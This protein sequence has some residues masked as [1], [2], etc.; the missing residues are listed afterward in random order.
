M[1]CPSWSLK[2]GASSEV[3]GELQ[4]K[5]LVLLSIAAEAIS[6][7][8]QGRNGECSG[9]PKAQTHS[10]LRCVHQFSTA[11]NLDCPQPHNNF[12]W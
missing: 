11:I 1:H 10:D 7:Q 4:K 6:K 5:E 9:V 2:S 8:I 12:W 3:Y